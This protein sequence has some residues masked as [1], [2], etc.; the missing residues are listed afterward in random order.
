MS[1]LCACT[2]GKV[3]RLNYPF[4]DFG[5][6]AV[7]LDWQLPEKARSPRAR[8]YGIDFKSEPILPS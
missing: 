7:D 5:F 1:E 6:A 3:Y 8:K 4:S 2:S